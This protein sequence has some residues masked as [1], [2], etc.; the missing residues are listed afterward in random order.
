M[1]R[2]M[3][4]VD[5]NRNKKRPNELER[6]YVALQFVFKLVLLTLPTLYM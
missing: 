4:K 2:Y 5:K 1:K 3:Y 6:F